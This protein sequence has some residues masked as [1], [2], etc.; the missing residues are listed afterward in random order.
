MSPELIDPQRFGFKKGCPTKSSD[1]YA[2]G[3]VIYEII[4]RNLP[5]HEYADL[6]V[7][8]KVSRGDLPPRGAR[9]TRSL[10]KML[11]LCWASHP[12]NRPSIEDVLQGL[13]MALNWPEPPSPGVDEEIGNGG[14]SWGPVNGS[15]GVDEETESDWG[16]VDADFTDLSAQSPFAVPVPPKRYMG[17]DGDEG[18][19]KV[20]A[21]YRTHVPTSQPLP[22]PIQGFSRRISPRPINPQR[23]SKY[24]DGGRHGSPVLPTGSNQKRPLSPT[25]EGGGGGEMKRPK[26]DGPKFS[27]TS[28]QT[29]ASSI[30]VLPPQ[31]FDRGLSES[32][33]PGSEASGDSKLSTKEKSNGKAAKKRKSGSYTTLLFLYRC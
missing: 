15:P 13:K 7:V 8:M 29:T 23:G 27:L 17:E 16:E 22:P 9:F 33:R 19:A 26:V 5:F 18:F 14:D 25:S 10:W 28:K 20:L 21:S 24:S 32:P 6:A 11:E 1:C 4:S 3:M 2:L 30:R 31:G 12:S